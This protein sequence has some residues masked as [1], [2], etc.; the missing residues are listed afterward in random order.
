VA[1]D[2]DLVDDDD[3]FCPAVIGPG[4]HNYQPFID[5]LAG[6]T[7]L[8]CTQ[9]GDTLEVYTLPAGANPFT[10]PS[11]SSAQAPSAPAPGANPLSNLFPLG[12][13]VP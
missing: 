9:C 3:P 11:A 13:T 1:I 4:I 8:Y 5:I 6:K 2:P 7:I 10:Q 12:N